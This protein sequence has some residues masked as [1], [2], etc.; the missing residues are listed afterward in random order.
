MPVHWRD[1]INEALDGLEN[2]LTYIWDVIRGRTPL[3]PTSPQDPQHPTPDVQDN[4]SA[5]G[6]T[7]SNEPRPEPTE[8]PKPTAGVIAD[9]ARWRFPAAQL[10]FHHSFLKMEEGNWRDMAKEYAEGRLREIEELVA[11]DE[12]NRKEKEAAEIEAKE[13]EVEEESIKGKSTKP[14]GRKRK[15]RRW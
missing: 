3:S 7:H 6:T 5:A 4:D 14:K 11:K 9:V 1:Q 15:R 8:P 12:A 10:Y 2:E 13:N